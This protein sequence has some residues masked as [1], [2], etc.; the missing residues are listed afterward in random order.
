MRLIIC[1]GS[2]TCGTRRRGLSCPRPLDRSDSGT[3]WLLCAGDFAVRKFDAPAP[4]IIFFDPFS[5]KT[6]GALWTLPAFREL[7]ALCSQKPGRSLYLHLFHERARSDAGSSVLRRQRPRTGPKAETTIAMSPLAA[8]SPHPHHLLGAEWLSKWRRSDA[9]A[10]FGSTEQDVS[11]H[12]AVL[13]HPQF[14]GPPQ[15]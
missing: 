1:A 3:E 6:D 8:L 9:Q 11:W 15:A 13:S 2:N 7:A 14:R 5:F 12:E 4:E 10:P